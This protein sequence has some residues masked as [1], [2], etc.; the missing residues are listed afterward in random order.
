M[1]AQTGMP[2]GDWQFWAATGLVVLV[3]GLVAWRSI[4]GSRRGRRHRVEITVDREGLADR[5]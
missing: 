2:W 4:S 1:I 5:D 3:V